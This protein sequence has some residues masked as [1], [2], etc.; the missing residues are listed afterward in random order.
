MHHVGTTLRPTFALLACGALILSGCNLIEPIPEFPGMAG[1]T[2]A[3]EKSVSQ[4]GIQLEVF[5]IQRPADDPMLGEALWGSLDQIG[6]V[7]PE[8]RETLHANGL[9]FGIAGRNPGYALQSLVRPVEERDSGT[10]TFRQEYQTPSGIAH[11]L[12][13]GVSHK[14]TT[15]N[16][17]NVSGNDSK[18]YSNV[19]GI[20]KCRVEEADGGWARLDIVPQLHFGQMRMRPVATGVSWDLDGRQEVDTLFSQRFQVELNQGEYL[21]LGY[22]G[23]ASD[24]VGECFFTS[25]EDEMLTENLLVIRIADIQRVEAVRQGSR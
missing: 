17:I 16:R 12:A 3:P 25:S 2:G 22:T 24:S 7:T 10:K 4:T 20:F 5:F 13:T 23:A 19:R 6:A 21:V 14:K 9:R 1:T 18:V 11:Q 8:V 15:V